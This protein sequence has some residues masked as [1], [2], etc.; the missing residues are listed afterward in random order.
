MSNLRQ[1]IEE[2]AVQFAQ[3]IVQAMRSASLD[4][5]IAITGGGNRIASPRT[6]APST[7]AIASPKRGPRIRN[8]RLGRRSAADIARTLDQIVSVLGKHPEGLRAEQI[9]AAL[10]I[11]KR[12]MPR[13]IA[14]GLSSG[15]LKKSGNKR[16]TVYT[17]GGAAGA[18]PKKAGKKPGKK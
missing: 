15:V 3:T 18:A 9:K 17:V 2:Q 16:A 11:D 5:L 10:Q 14:E 12:E 13:P 4:E 8:G 7:T 1:T 6:A